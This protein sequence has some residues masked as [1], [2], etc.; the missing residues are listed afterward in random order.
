M[1]CWLSIPPELRTEQ[2]FLTSWQ[3]KRSQT[4][5]CPLPD[6]FALE[7]VCR[8]CLGSAARRFSGAER[9]LSRVLSRDFTGSQAP[10]SFNAEPLSQVIFT[11]LL[12]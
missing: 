11:H 3:A 1:T 2:P 9:V 4:Y 8:S 10:L 12:S 5:R 7:F 6:C